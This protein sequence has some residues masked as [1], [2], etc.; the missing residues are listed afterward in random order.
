MRQVMPNRRTSLRVDL[1]RPVVGREEEDPAGRQQARDLA[2]QWLGR[3]AVL[4]HADGRDGAEVPV[5][6]FGV[7]VMSPTR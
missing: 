6:P 5:R 4:D 1:L 7:A 2:Q 3:E